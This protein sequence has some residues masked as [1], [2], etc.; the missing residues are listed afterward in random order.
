M[1]RKK[2]YIVRI[3][4]TVIEDYEVEAI[5]E[6]GARSAIERGEGTLCN[7]VERPDMEIESVELNA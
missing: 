3:K 1:A 7:E 2:S 6:S 4:S 5:N